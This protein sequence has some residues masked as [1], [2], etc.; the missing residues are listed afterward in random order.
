VKDEGEKRK[1]GEDVLVWERVRVCRAL[2][3]LK[4]RMRTME[5]KGGWVYVGCKIR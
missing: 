1:V 4:R 3:N 2:L 5:V